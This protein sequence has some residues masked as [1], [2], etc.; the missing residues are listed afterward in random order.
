MWSCEPYR[1]T[2]F[3]QK[4]Y[5]ALFVSAAILTV[6]IVLSYA[7]IMLLQRNAERS[8]NTMVQQLLLLIVEYTLTLPQLLQLQYARHHCCC[9]CCY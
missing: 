1:A 7:V 5:S 3:T 9:C 2:L 4:Q 6:S 8:T